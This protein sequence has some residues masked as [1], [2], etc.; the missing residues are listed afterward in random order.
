MIA[1]IKQ[2]SV[3]VFLI[4]VLTTGGSVPLQGGSTCQMFIEDCDVIPAI[5]PAIFVWSCDS[6]SCDEAEDG[7]EDCGCQDPQCNGETCGAGGGSCG[8]FIC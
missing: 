1:R 3:L 8:L 5:P 4:A 7:I 6:L 2:L